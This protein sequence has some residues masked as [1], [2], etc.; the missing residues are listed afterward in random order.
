MADISQ[1]FGGY[2]QTPASNKKPSCEGFF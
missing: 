1:S 2:L